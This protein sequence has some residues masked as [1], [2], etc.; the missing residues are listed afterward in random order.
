MLP[1]PPKI[2]FFLFFNI[3]FLVTTHPADQSLFVSIT[4]E[5]ELA[6]QWNT[7]S[8]AEHRTGQGQMNK[9]ETGQPRTSY[10]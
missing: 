7:P 4:T 5:L 9:I 2:L 8:D 10:I 1:S 3:C 6:T